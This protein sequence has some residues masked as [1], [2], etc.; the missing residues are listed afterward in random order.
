MERLE[1]EADVA[2]A[3]ERR[4]LR[5][6]EDG[7]LAVRF[8]RPALRQDTANLSELRA[9]DFQVQRVFGSVMIALE[10]F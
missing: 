10:A 4:E 9:E 6:R 1:D 5:A 8:R 2:P 3:Q 7:Q